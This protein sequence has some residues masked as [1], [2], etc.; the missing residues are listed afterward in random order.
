MDWKINKHNKKK[1]KKKQ[2]N[3]LIPFAV[4]IVT[5]FIAFA[6]SNNSDETMSAITI[7]APVV[8]NLDKKV[9]STNNDIN[10]KIP[11]PVS[12][13]SDPVSFNLVQNG[14]QI[15]NTLPDLPDVMLEMK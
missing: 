8:E 10:I 9:G 11:V 1:N 15:P 6:Y 14:V 4:A 7:T 3:L 5:W 12:E 2:V 13:T